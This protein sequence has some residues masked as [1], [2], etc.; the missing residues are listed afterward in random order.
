MIEQIAPAQFNAWLQQQDGAQP[1]VLDVRD[2]MELQV[3]Q[4]QPRGFD[5]VHI[6]MYDIPARLAE[7]DPDRPMACLCHHG[8]RSQQVAMFLQRQG[9]AQVVNL[10]G[11]IDAWAAQVDPSVPRY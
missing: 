7:L 8:I 4:L 3:A 1:L 9:F 2:P 10:A 11:G 6:P 5:L